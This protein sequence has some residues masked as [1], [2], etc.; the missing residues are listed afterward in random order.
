[1]KVTL[2]Q[3]FSSNHSNGFQVVGIFESVDDATKVET[4]LKQLLN[5]ATHWH[6]ENPLAGISEAEA[7]IITEFALSKD[8]TLFVDNNTQDVYRFDNIVELTSSSDSWVRKFPFEELLQKLGATNMAAWD[9]LSIDTQDSEATIFKMTVKGTAPDMETLK[10]IH[11]FW[12]N[13]LSLASEKIEIDD[14]T[15]KFL[16]D[17]F[18]INKLQVMV[19]KLREQNCTDI[20]Y[21]L[22][23]E[24]I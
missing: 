11:E 18:D 19:K 1:M 3:Q 10:H 6:K 8:E 21:H 17:Y 14:L 24:K 15:I 5:E 2:W 22:T 16:E 4:R 23:K 7:Q 20:E 9:F 13:R 12:L